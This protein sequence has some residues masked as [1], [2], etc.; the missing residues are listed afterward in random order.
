MKPGSLRGGV[1]YGKQQET[2]NKKHQ[3]EAIFFPQIL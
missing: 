3:I 2:A 1:K